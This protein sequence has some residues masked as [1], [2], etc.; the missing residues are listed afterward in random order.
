MKKNF[1]IGIITLISLVILYFGVNFMKG[2]NVFKSTNSYYAIFENVSGLYVSSPIYVEGFQVGLINDVDV[3]SHNP[4]R[5]IV[6]M[7][8]DNGFHVK[9]GSHVEFSTD[10]FGSSIVNVIMPERADFLQPGD[11]IL[12]YQQKG[13]MDGAASLMPTVDKIALRFDSV[14]TTLNAILADPALKT[15]IKGVDQ[16]VAE[17]HASSKQMNVLMASLKND[18]AQISSNLAK[19]STDLSQFS[20]E[21]KEVDIAQTMKTIDATIRNLEELTHKVNSTDNTLGALVNDRSLHD[22]LSATLATTTQLLEEIKRNP[23][24]YLNVRVRLFR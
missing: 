24:K 5:F 13:L 22:S 21:L 16:T 4:M 19:V 8:F 6:K 18:M 3:H 20:G 17:L 14:L 2:V 12:G 11:T 1:W 7:N 23:E 9:K 10:V 15:T